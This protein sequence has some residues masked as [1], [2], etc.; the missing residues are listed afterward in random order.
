[1]AP[2]YGF[3]LIVLLGLDVPC[4]YRDVSSIAPVNPARIQ[5]MLK[6]VR[7]G[8]MN[9]KTRRKKCDEVRPKCSDCKRLNL[10]CQW[11]DVPSSCVSHNSS[12]RDQY[13]EGQLYGLDTNSIA[14]GAL[15]CDGTIIT[16][17][18]SSLN[19]GDPPNAL[20]LLPDHNETDRLL[21]NH[22]IHAVAEV[23]NRSSFGSTNPFVDMLLPVAYSSDITLS[24]I[25]SLSG[26]HWRRVY[27]KAYTRSLVH[28][29]RAIC[30]L[31]SMLSQRSNH[32]AQIQATTTVMLLCLGELA[33]G[34]STAWEFHLNA[35]EKLL[36]SKIV[37]TTEACQT[38]FLDS[39]FHYLD[40]VTT[41][42]SCRKP[43]LKQARISHEKDELVPDQRSTTANA[44][45]EAIYGV[46]RKL[47]D[48]IGRMNSLAQRRSTRADPGM[49]AHFEAEAILLHSDLDSWRIVHD[50]ALQNASMSETRKVR[51][52]SEALEWA[53][54]LR[55]HQIV[56]GY[57]NL[58]PA[59]KRATSRIVEAIAAIRNGSRVEGCL[60]FPLVI[61]GASTDSE[62]QRV[63]IKQRLMVMENTLGFGHI[64]AALELLEK[65]WQARENRDAS[66]EQL[67]VVNWAEMRYHQFPGTVFL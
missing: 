49:N 51:L 32:T 11:P 22:Y 29:G 25:L 28:Q 17:V 57:D 20:T 4:T 13:S 62:E 24:A 48:F 1:M 8:C 42:S 26:I 53:I 37:R 54:R 12:L 65:V 5:P 10:F 43:L 41:I 58:H 7:T 38:N 44:S 61:A 63:M 30:G 67:P 18:E 46:P 45:T 21:L 9:C 59:A 52:A 2:H 36:R 15:V 50:N 47:F 55:M 6:R 23:F 19:A 66:P 39:L 16:I 27:P 40:A 56:V 60:L 3:A 64:T 31:A 34:R 33:D 14:G 35:A